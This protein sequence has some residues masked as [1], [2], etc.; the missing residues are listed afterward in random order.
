[1]D[2]TDNSSNAD[3]IL[4]Y[5]R[6]FII[7]P[8]SARTVSHAPRIRIE[9]TGRGWAVVFSGDTLSR[10]TGEFEYA[11]MLPSSR[12]KEYYAEYRYESLAAAAGSGLR[13]MFSLLGDGEYYAT[14][15]PED[16]WVEFF[17]QARGLCRALDI[18]DCLPAEE[19]IKS[20]YRKMAEKH[21]TSSC[22]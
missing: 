22:R 11:G 13:A 4:G 19:N 1:M 12:N 18:E 10:K 7:E 15:M 16:Q 5:A 14:R 8:P 6:V 2:R 9:N 3:I 20:V 17:S 21:S